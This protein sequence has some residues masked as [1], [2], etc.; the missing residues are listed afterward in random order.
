MPIYEYI[1]DDCRVEFEQLITGGQKPNCPNCDSAKL[2]KK[3]SV[4]STPGTGAAATGEVCDPLP[5]GG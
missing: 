2:T 4:I 5:G 1:C 3:L